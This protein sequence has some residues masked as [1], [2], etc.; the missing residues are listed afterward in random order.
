MAGAAA[1]KAASNKKTKYLALQQTHLFVPVSVETMGSWNVDSINFVSTI[2]KKLTE[3]SGDQ[4]ET[5]YLF[6]RD[7]YYLSLF[8]EGMKFRL[9]EPGQ[10][11]LTRF[12]DQRNVFVNNN[13]DNNNNNIHKTVSHCLACSSKMLSTGFQLSCSVCLFVCLFVCCLTANQHHLGH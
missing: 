8:R 10:S 2:C 6:K 5:S 12:C 1:D 7:K 9:L 4:L 13:G 11:C 3:V